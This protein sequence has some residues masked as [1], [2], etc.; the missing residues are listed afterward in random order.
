MAVMEYPQLQHLPIFLHG[1]SSGLDRH[2]DIRRF[3]C[4]E[5]LP[6]LNI[7]IMAGSRLLRLLQDFFL[8]SLAYPFKARCVSPPTSEREEDLP[9]LQ[10]RPPKKVSTTACAEHAVF[11]LSVGIPPWMNRVLID[12]KAMAVPEKQ[13]WGITD[14]CDLTMP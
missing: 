6:D 2:L 8:G 7:P 5:M 13:N 1:L 4:E 14:C 9:P 3:L 11:R 12:S 10:P